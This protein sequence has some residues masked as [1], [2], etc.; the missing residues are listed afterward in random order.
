MIGRLLQAGCWCTPAKDADTAGCMQGYILF[1]VTVCIDELHGMEQPELQ[2]CDCCESSFDVSHSCYL[3]RLP[4]VFTS[5][6]VH[7]QLTVITLWHI[8]SS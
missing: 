2:P 3:H 1:Y 7:K 4:Q 6:C 5:T 8:Y